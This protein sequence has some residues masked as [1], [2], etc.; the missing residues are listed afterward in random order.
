MRLFHEGQFEGRVVRL[1]VFLGR[2]PDEVVERDLQLFYKKLLNAIDKPAFRD[3][4]WSLC[5]RSG[6]PDNATFQN[7]LAWNW[8]EDDE[9]YLIIVN[10]GESSAQARV[11]VPWADPGDRKLRLR[12]E[13]SGVVYDR[14]VEEMRSQGLYVDLGPWQYHFLRCGSDPFRPVP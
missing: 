10:F 7:V 13:I 3:G 9:R 14:S 2:R 1:P 4:Q 12:D 5:E 8:L 6:W 11:Q